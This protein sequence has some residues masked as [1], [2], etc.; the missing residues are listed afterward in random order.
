VSGLNRF[1]RFLLCLALVL[2]ALVVILTLRG[3]P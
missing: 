1:N 3:E 2:Y